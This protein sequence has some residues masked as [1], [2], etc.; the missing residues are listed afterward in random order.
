MASRLLR[1][2]A[3]ALGVIGVALAVL[4][5]RVVLASRDELARAESLHERGRI[6]AA[7]LH[8][9]RAARWYAPASPYPP[10]ALERL[11]S[12]AVEAEDEGQRERALSAW[13]SIRAAIMSTRSFYTPFEGRLESANERIAELMA[14]GEPPPIDAGKSRA[15]LRREHLALLTQPRRPRLVFSFAAVVGLAV[16]VGAAFAFSRRAID[17]E[18]RLRPRQAVRWGIA[19]LAGFAL[20][21]VGLALA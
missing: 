15:T 17:E 10:R 2:L 1:R 19:F 7:I 12:L 5:V 16:W 3:A 6:D 20:F 14:A 4:S 21:A 11:A 9:R 13:R 18:D 8:Y